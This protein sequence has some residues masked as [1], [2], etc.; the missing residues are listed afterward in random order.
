MS[1]EPISVAEY[2]F[3]DVAPGLLLKDGR[4]NVYPEVEGKDYFQ[5]R[6]NKNGMQIQARG[7]VGVIPINDELVLHVS[8][9]VP[10]SNL[11]RL[12]SV[13]QHNP[14]ALP[15]LLRS[16][17]VEPGLYPSLISLYAASLKTTVEGLHQQGLLRRYERREQDYSAPRGRINIGRTMQTAVPRGLL[18]VSTTY[19]E[20]TTDTPE[21][22]ALLAA[23][24]WLARYAS[25]YAYVLT[26]KVHRQVQRDLNVAYLLLASATHDPGR[27]FLRDPVVIGMRP[28]PSLRPDYRPALD[29]AL[30]IL[31]QQAVVID[32]TGK[33]LQMPSLLID[34]DHVFEGYIREVL[35][36]A[37]DR[38]GWPCAILDGNKQ[39]PTGAQSQLFHQPD[40]EHVETSPDVVCQRHDKATPRHPVLIEVKYKPIGKRVDRDHLDQVLT[41]GLTYGAP[42]AVIVQPLGHKPG[43]RGL[44]SLG[45]VGGITCHVYSID[46]NGDLAQEEAALSAAIHNLIDKVPTT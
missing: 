34:L 2:G 29:L 5:P 16:Y 26:S 18:A 14:I 46:L 9:R 32:Q 8:P 6:L 4:L 36:L 39:P 43:H 37:A 3:V 1:P 12:L 7:F 35:R 41:Y 15:G 33:R 11:A 13:V 40:D 45:T 22:Q 38:E 25:R 31:S 23:V 42:Q 30:S 27:A 44:R 24:L 19:F 20:R 17:D 10:L 21:N 28:L